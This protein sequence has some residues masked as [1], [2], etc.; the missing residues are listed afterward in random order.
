VDG[1]TASKVLVSSRVRG[2]LAG[3]EIVDVGL[4]NEA[5][6]IEMLLSAAGQPAGAAAPLEARAVVQVPA[7]RAPTRETVAPHS[8]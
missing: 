7:R 4:P 8:C 5:E 3:S 2:L 6:A 1:G